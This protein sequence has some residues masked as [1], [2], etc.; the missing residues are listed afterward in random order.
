MCTSCGADGGVVPH[1]R[2]RGEADVFAAV[3]HEAL[4]LG[5]M[6]CSMRDTRWDAPSE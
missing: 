6:V 4:V 3:E 2:Q 1:T 5:V